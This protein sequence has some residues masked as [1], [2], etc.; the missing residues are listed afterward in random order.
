MFFSSK[1]NELDKSWGSYG[2]NWGR[3]EHPRAISFTKVKFGM[4]FDAGY[5][6]FQFR[7]NKLVLGLNLDE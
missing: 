2:R 4:Y 3:F 7:W 1:S 5:P 6:Y